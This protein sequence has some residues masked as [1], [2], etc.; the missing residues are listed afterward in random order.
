MLDRFFILFCF[1]KCCHSK[2]TK[3]FSASPSSNFWSI[4]SYIC[5]LLSS[6]ISHSWWRDPKERRRWM[7]YSLN[8]LAKSAK[9]RKFLLQLNG[10]KC[11]EPKRITLYVLIIRELSFCVIKYDFIRWLMQHL[12]LYPHWGCLV[13]WFDEVKRLQRNQFSVFR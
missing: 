2:L 6:L 1:W 9:N 10:E 3:L 11:L 13:R 12:E 4:K 8:P 7:N 5:S